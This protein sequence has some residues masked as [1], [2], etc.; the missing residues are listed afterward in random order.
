[1]VLDEHVR[2]RREINKWYR[3]A[4]K[5]IEGITF[6]TEPDDGYFSNYWLTAIL[7]DPEKCGGKTRE[8][9]QEI[10]NS[11]NIE[12]RPLWKPLHLQPVFK[13]IPYYGNSVAESHFEKGL[14]LPSHPM[15]DETDLNRI[16]NVIK[17]TVC[18]ANLNLF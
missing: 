3:E 13:D 1:M 16:V 17:Q 12:V 14:C 5:D 18:I 15:L 7:V 11:E 8:D 2:R 6:Q 4:L 9:I 10:M